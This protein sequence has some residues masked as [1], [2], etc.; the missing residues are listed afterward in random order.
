M[1][2]SLLTIAA[3]V[4]L[5]VGSGAQAQG[6]VGAAAGWTKLSADC[7]EYAQCDKTGTGGKLYGGFK[8]ANQLAVEATYFDWGKATGEV[9]TA[10]A[11]G[12]SGRKVALAV[13]N[14]ATR[15]DELRTTGFGVG[16]A[17]FMP[18]AT[19]WTGAARLGVA[20]NKGKATQSV[21]AVTE[22]ESK[23]STQPYIGL[24][25]GYNVSSNMTITGEVDFSRV[26]YPS[27]GG[28]FQTDRLQMYTL[29]LRF[30]F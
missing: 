21:A 29:G 19:D 1:R 15:R 5:L 13:S 12:V 20:Q 23:R 25:I 14:V 11:D 26:K 8:F 2:K 30:A 10:S 24:G 3:G 22:S 6:Y 18:F 28:E 9:A 17:Y 4:A 16:V 7:S 27:G